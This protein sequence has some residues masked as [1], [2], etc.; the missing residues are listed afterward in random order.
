MGTI[1]GML[2]GEHEQVN[3]NNSV[4]EYSTNF[5]EIFEEY[6]LTHRIEYLVMQRNIFPCV[7]G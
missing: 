3:M 5:D 4:L 7:H 1:S 6:Y 2:F